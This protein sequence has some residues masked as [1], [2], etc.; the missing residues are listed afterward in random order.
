M[1]RGHPILDT[2]RIRLVYTGLGFFWFGRYKKSPM[3]KTGVYGFNLFIGV[4]R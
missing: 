4:K 1:K 3:Y 2:K